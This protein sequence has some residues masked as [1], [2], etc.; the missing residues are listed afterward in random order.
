MFC[1]LGLLLL[2]PTAHAEIEQQTLEGPN[3][4]VD[5]PKVILINKAAEERINQDILEY[6][7][8]FENTTEGLAKGRFRYKLKSETDT[9]ISLLFVDFRYSA[10]AA[11]GNTQ[12]TGIVY[13]KQTGE[14]IPLS[15]FANVT[16]EDLSYLLHTGH[17]YN[18]SD[19]QV[20][21]GG[22]FFGC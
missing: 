18:A 15:D 11:H 5:Y 10:G 19:E 1:I 6:V 8:E 20:E 12:E 4:T 22:S 7:Q 16:K 21:W 14:H 9:Y 3:C 17:L 2:L 13:S